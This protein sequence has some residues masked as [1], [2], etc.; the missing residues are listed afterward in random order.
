MQNRRKTQNKRGGK[1][2]KI[3]KN[4]SRRSRTNRKSNGN[5]ADSQELK[6]AI[7]LPNM[8]E[9]MKIFKDEDKKLPSMFRF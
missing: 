3:Y 4:K 7:T 2:K 5:N 8:K 1:A 6:S 9:Y